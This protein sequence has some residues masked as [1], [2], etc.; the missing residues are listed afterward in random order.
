MSK[1]FAIE[2]ENREIQCDDRDLRLLLQF[3]CQCL[4]KDL[5]I[6]EIPK[7]RVSEVVEVETQKV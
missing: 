5:A 3:K 2:I 4:L 6:K 7:V 1:F